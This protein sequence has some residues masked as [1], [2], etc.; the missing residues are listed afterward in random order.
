MARVSIASLLEGAGTP[1]VTVPEGGGANQVV[2]QHGMI[3]DLYASGSSSSVTLDFGLAATPTAG[4]DVTLHDLLDTVSGGTAHLPL[5]DL[6]DAGI[7]AV[8]LGFAGEQRVP[9]DAHATAG[10]QSA[11][12]AIAVP[13][14]A[15]ATD[16]LA[17]AGLFENGRH[18][19]QTFLGGGG[20]PAP[21]SEH[22]CI[23]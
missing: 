9:G 13:F 2:G 6:F 17:T 23:A 4:V 20:L 12:D 7:G 10:V 21:I 8:P 3:A 19:L 1:I 15:A 14:A 18:E 16:N 5:A 22:H 11:L